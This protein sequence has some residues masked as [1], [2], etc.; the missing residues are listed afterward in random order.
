MSLF[1]RKK[2]GLMIEAAAIATAQQETPGD[3]VQG[4]ISAFET[5]MVS[6][7]CQSKIFAD[8]IYTDDAVN[9]L[10]GLVVVT[11]T[12]STHNFE[13]LRGRLSGYATICIRCFPGPAGRNSVKSGWRGAK[14]P[15]GSW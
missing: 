14:N 3:F 11:L 15:T 1:F 13:L 7:D 9:I 4:R 6:L 5:A 8:T 10:C 12:G 2:I